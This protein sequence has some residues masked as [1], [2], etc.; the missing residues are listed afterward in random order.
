[1]TFSIVAKCPQTGQIGIGAATA[2]PAVGKLLTHASAGVGAVATQAKLNPYLG[3][4][5]LR[6]L[7]QGRSATEVRDILARDDPRAQHRQF[8]ILD[9]DGSTA[10]WTGEACI[11][12]AGARSSE[13]LSVQGNRL[14]GP[15]VVDAAWHCFRASSGKPIDERLMEALEAADRAGG[16]KHGEHSATIYIVDKEEY[17]LW[18]I[19]VDAHD[20]P[21]AELRRLHDIFSR[22]VIPEILSMPTRACP[23]GE[24][25][26]DDA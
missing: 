1:M 22:S 8:A 19:R 4:D 2:V 12:W 23:G 10:V 25:A 16:D 7:Q 20:Q 13:N 5:G 9:R 26:E 17:P 21:F 6:L 24:E 3:I 18:D 15:H 14:A 11:S